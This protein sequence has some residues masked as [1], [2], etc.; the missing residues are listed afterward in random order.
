MHDIVSISLVPGRVIER[1]GYEGT[2]HC[3]LG[4]KCVYLGGG[5]VRE[6]ST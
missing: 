3:E 5:E 1:P 6:D 2:R 4:Y